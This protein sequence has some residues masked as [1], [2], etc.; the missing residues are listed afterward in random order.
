MGGFSIFW[1]I[2]LVVT[3]VVLFGVILVLR[4][5]LFGSKE[6]S[7]SKMTIVRAG[8]LAAIVLFGFG[9]FYEPIVNYWTLSEVLNVHGRVGSVQYTGSD[10]DGFLLVVDDKGRFMPKSSVV[11]EFRDRRGEVVGQM[12]GVSNVNGLVV[13]DGVV[14]ELRAGMYNIRINAKN[15]GRKRVTNTQVE[16]RSSPLRMYLYSDRKIYKPGHTV[17]FAGYVWKISSDSF[18]PFSFEALNISVKNEEEL[19]I[20]K[21]EM[22]TDD[23]GQFTIDFPLSVTLDEGTYSFEVQAGNMTES[24]NVFVEKY[25]KPTV[26]LDISTRSWVVRGESLDVDFLASYL[27]GEPVAEGY[28]QISVY[29]MSQTSRKV[30]ETVKV[31]DGRYKYTFDTNRLRYQSPRDYLVIEG[32]ITDAA[33]G[34]E[35]IE[36]KSVLVVDSG[37]LLEVLPDVNTYGTGDLV[38][39][40]IA[41]RKPDG[42]SASDVDSKITVTKYYNGRSSVV[43]SEDKRFS[44]E[45]NYVFN[46]P[47]DA[48]YLTVQVTGTSG[49]YSASAATQI[50][51]RPDNY[52][53]CRSGCGSFAVPEKYKRDIVV[54]P[55]KIEYKRG[56]RVVASVYARSHYANKPVVITVSNPFGNTL[57]TL[58]LDDNARGEIVLGYEDIAPFAT[59]QGFVYNNGFAESEPVQVSACADKK[60][61]VKLD[62]LRRDYKPGDIVD[63][64]VDTGK[65]NAQV[66]LGVVDESI[67]LLKDYEFEPFEALYSFEEAGALNKVTTRNPRTSGD[68]GLFFSLGMLVLVLVSGYALSVKYIKE[69]KA[70]SGYHGADRRFL[71]LGVG[72]VFVIIGTFLLAIMRIVDESPGFFLFG[73]GSVAILISVVEMIYGA[74]IKGQG[75]KWLAVTGLMGGLMSALPL[76]LVVLELYD[77]D[78]DILLFLVLG[79]ILLLIS[80][81]GEWIKYG[82]RYIKKSRTV[83]GYHGADKRFLALGVGGVIVIIGTFLLT[84]MR[85][86]DDE[87][88]LFFLFGMGSIMILVSVVERTYDA[89]RKNRGSMWLATIGLV[90]GLVSALPLLL[91]VLKVYKPEEEI[92]LFLVLGIILLLISFIGEGIKCDS[93]SRSVILVSSIVVFVM[94]IVFV[95]SIFSVFTGS[96]SRMSADMAYDDAE[97]IRSINAPSVGWGGYHEKGMAEELSWRGK[98]VVPPDI[99][100]R[101]SFPDTA[102]WMP[103]LR[104]DGSGKVRVPVMLPD[105]I[106]AWRVEALAATRNAEVGSAKDSL[107]SK[108]DYFVKAA[109][110]SEVTV[111]DEVTVSMVVFNNLDEAIESRVCVSSSTERC[112]MSSSKFKIVSGEP[113]KTVVVAAHGSK[114]ARWRVKFTGYGYANMSFLAYSV[115]DG[116]SD[117]LTKPVLVKPKEEIKSDIYSGIVD[118][119]N[120]VEFEIFRGAIPEFTN[121]RLVIQPSLEAVSLDSVEELARYP[122]GC[123]EQVMSGLYP[124]VIVKQY[125][126][127]SGQLTPEF[128]SKLDKMIISGLQK[129][130]GFHHRDG[131]WGW[132]QNDKTKVFMSAY[133]LYGLAEARN[134]GFF[135][136]DAYIN[137]A[138]KYLSSVQRQDGS[139][140]G[141]GHLSREDMTMTATCAHALLNSGMD[142]DSSVVKKAMNYLYG[143]YKSGEMKSPYVVALYA[144]CLEKAGDDSTLA[145]VLSKL[146]GM[147]RVDGD[148][149]YWSDDK[150]TRYYSYSLGGTVTTTATAS[151]ALVNSENVRYHD[152]V[153]GAVEWL[154][155][156]RGGYG[157]GQTS[158]TAAVLKV[159]TEYARLSDESVDGKIR[160]Y[161]NEAHIGSYD[162]SED[163]RAIV[164]EVGLDYKVGKNVLRFSKEGEGT[165]YYTLNVEQV[166]VQED[167]NEKTLGITK[168]LSRT[169]VMVGDA[170]PVTISVSNSGDSVYYIVVEDVVP[171]GFVVDDASLEKIVS[172]S[173]NLVEYEVSENNVY[174]YIGALGSET[175]SYDLKAVNEGIVFAAPARVY[176]MYDVENADESLSYSV[177]IS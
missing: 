96:M 109:P 173:E 152:S 71:A 34:E 92:L 158:D 81:I 32:K 133:V 105:T 28:L 167:I 13:F 52:W 84:M 54:E 116:V 4:M 57:T 8:S 86:V 114:S 138:Q 67:M 49:M 103:S 61:D 36:K 91:A 111:G 44:S 75:S 127:R 153:Q 31:H 147:K 50:N 176:S 144:L 131:G 148:K 38:N 171:P 82:G 83:S 123:A 165:A 15:H 76:L 174:F 7:H 25:E 164:Y 78:D 126:S 88:T 104:A 120:T 68:G 80:F 113:S 115:S 85:I 24:Y 37:L 64:T 175:F 155:S 137:G 55:D 18:A 135:I 51:F 168:K 40:K 149:V 159:I 117:G 169:K 139:F 1:L 48:D 29:S 106:T 98:G 146:D 125:L 66:T 43:F 2:G 99:K 157:W 21:K 160:V 142:A 23:Y 3:L 19:V 39:V 150:S 10:F 73:V 79:I 41:A 129:I 140:R 17:Y 9:L 166:R 59:V 107:I 108:M 156:K 128:E 16:V 177:E 121:A 22:K 42:L 172:G 122:H 134:A 170:L 72:G 163:D 12:A 63:L 87:D 30:S 70:V 20:Y 162:V 151:L 62:F 33:S 119:D 46:Y 14:P 58:N 100:I 6:L 35:R 118:V 95:V 161:L 97:M 26:N 65:A 136:D 90:G 94:L 53:N 77:L 101:T 102:L 45:Y 5:C 141:A 56:E 132:Y 154:V 69:D 74:F 112:G 110:P 27:F 11:L 145:G 130:Y 93:R 124:D 47:Q 89:F 143:K 60:V